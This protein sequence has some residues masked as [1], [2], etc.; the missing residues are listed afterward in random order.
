MD[1]RV[2]RRIASNGVPVRP[3]RSSRL[4]RLG[5][6]AKA[7]FKVVALLG[8]LI[9]TIVS[10]EEPANPKHYRKV[11][12]QY[13]L[14]S[15]NDFPQRDPQDWRLLGSNDGGK[16]WT[17]LDS[18]K[19]ESFSARHQRRLFKIANTN[20]F[21]MYQ[22]QIDHIRDRKVANCVQLS[23]IELMG[24]S[25]A[26]LDPVPNFNDVI[27]AQGDNP[28]AETVR[29]LFD[30]RVE[31]KWLDRPADRIT[32][33]SWIQWQYSP[34]A[35]ATI[36]NA[37]QLLS[38]R[39]RAGDGYPVRMEAIVCSQP[40]DSH[41]L[42]LVDTTEGIELRNVPNAA[43]F[44]PGQHVLVT[45]VSE[46]NADH[47]DILR[48]GVQL[49]G[50][51]TPEN[52]EWVPLEQPLASQEQKW[53]EIR[54]QIEFPTASGD[55]H[56]FDV[57]DAARSMK[58]R[59]LR[60]DASHPLPP[61]GTQV[62]VRGI[63]QGAF[64]DRGRWV[65]ANLW[66]S[67]TDAISL[68]SPD[69]AGGGPTLSRP[70]AANLNKETNS[71]TK[72][73]QIRKL[74]QDEL[75][76]RP[77]VKI[78]GII[79][80]LIGAFIQDDTAGIEVAFPDAESRKI[81]GPGMF[82]EV[83]GWG[84][85]GDVGNPIV[86]A[87]HI[88]VIGRGKFPPPQHLSLNQLMSGRMDG[89]WI[90][91]DGVVRSTDGAH[92][93]MISQGQE[94]TASVG[95]G[96]IA[97]V[98]GLVDAA[99][100][101]RGVGVTALDDNGRIQGVHLLIPSLEHVDVL[102]PPI[103]PFSKPIQP[104]GSLLGLNVARQS[105]HRVHVEGTLTLLDNQ[106]FFLQDDTG[107]A[108][109]IFQEDVA[110]DPRFG[111]SRWLFWRSQQ[112]NSAF[113]FNQDLSPGD[114]VQIVGFPETHG[115][116][117]VL[118]EVILRKAGSVA[119]VEP[120]E[121]TAGA[122]ASGT[123]DSTLVTLDGIVRGQN[124]LGTHVVMALEWN[125]R[126][127]QVLVPTNTRLAAIVPG[128]RVR[129]T[130][131]CQ[132]DPMPY[133]ELGLRV[134]SVRVLARSPTDL[135]ILA[136]P[137]WWTMQRALAAMGA[138]GFVIFAAFIWIKQ[139]RRQIE[140]RTVQLTAEIQLREQTERQRSLEK[141]RARIAQ[142]LH[143]DLG[144]NLTQIVFLSQRVED[145]RQHAQESERWLGLIPATARRTIQSL[146]EIV[147]AINPRHDSLES[148][149]NYLSQ[150]A[151]QH[152]MLAGVRC[153]LDVPTVLPAVPL[154]AEVRHKLL[155]AAREALQNVATHASATEARVTL[156]LD[157]EAL[158]I[159]IADDGGGFDSEHARSGG[160]G[161]HN[162]H[163]RLEDIGGSLEIVSSSDKGTT[164]RL[165]IRRDQLHGRVIGTTGHAAP[166]Y[167]NGQHKS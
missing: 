77:P 105:S 155:L 100:R 52:P 121:V 68:I 98:N 30:G 57:Q 48:P 66:A 54:G 15:A 73:E 42:L 107:S 154:S 158:V 3:G 64:D 109:A 53:V 147:W 148:L 84:G 41:R 94:V 58:V 103:D 91:L 21:E 10:G 119:A 93:L 151:Q 19:G 104:I 95:R 26:D 1:L 74:S 99:V 163:R 85:V 32:C 33:A 115:Y 126:A 130:G 133:A 56:Y 25:E 92:L 5:C 156:Q 79:T 63:A 20:A 89:Q 149:A 134:G 22:L 34:P 38:L 145:A 102:E 110:L 72:I 23:E 111:R 138:M 120:K 9:P 83:E 112:T 24:E 87:D 143:D 127:L 96:S 76:K 67:G 39:A 101:V 16:T 135:A 47:V 132:T 13:A 27:A 61:S 162:M 8:L 167:E 131:V 123:L 12:R 140:E 117:P 65:A 160:N 50:P 141:E 4:L 51:L 164:V 82:V 36:T 108:M 165:L 71:L 31:T 139:L 144:A 106:R 49:L 2:Q 114:H 40:K 14:I 157:D 17:T 118:T 44:K 11:I 35:D 128:T 159:L 153:V 43:Q 113:K 29:N 78:R 62:A 142:D 116:S 59:L 80:D 81:T 124:I 136:R 150:F 70:E 86:S 6:R 137:P 7:W 55:K 97:I 166:G 129:V 69:N 88:T 122:I 28:P 75:N 46:W 60:W 152:L 125:D 161:L 45:G 18:R 90:E 146:D 37:S